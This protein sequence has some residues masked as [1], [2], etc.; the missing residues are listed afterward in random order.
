MRWRSAFQLAT[1][2][3]FRLSSR[4]LVASTDDNDARVEQ[5]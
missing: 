3:G 1:M 4:S 2:R 5:S